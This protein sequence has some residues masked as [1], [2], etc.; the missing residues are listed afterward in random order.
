MFTQNG[1]LKMHERIHTGVKSYVC[2]TCV[3]MCTQSTGSYLGFMYGYIQARNH[4][5]T[6]GNVFPQSTCLWVNVHERIHADVKTYL[7]LQ[8]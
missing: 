6:C 4:S 2:S 7:S 5:S 1:K 3:K 8:I